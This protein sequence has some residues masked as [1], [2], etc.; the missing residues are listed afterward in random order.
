MFEILNWTDL[1]QLPL[2]RA[3]DFYPLY[4]CNPIDAEIL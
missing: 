3:R 1:N 2:R 4:K